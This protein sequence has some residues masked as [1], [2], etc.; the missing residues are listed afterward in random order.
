MR[1]ILASKSPRRKEILLNMGLA[2][3]IVTADTD[4]SSD[5]TD[6]RELCEELSLRKAIAVRDHLLAIGEL[7]P[8][9][10]II[11]SDTVVECEGEIL[12]KPKDKE[13]A[14]RMLTSLSGRAHRVFSG[15]ALV[16]ADESKVSHSVTAVY[17]DEIE[18]D[19]LERYLDT[20]E[21]YD[22][23]GAYGIQGY[24][25]RWIGRIDGC[26]FGVVG[27]SANVLDKLHRELTGRPIK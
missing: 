18:K 22:K 1:Y 24:A 3:D 19:D 15:I 13:D 14:R 10:I 21:P 17:V 2:F 26:Y 5:I 11:A 16:R 6:A 20:N 9:D 23:A 8:A 27:M 4:E 12:G 25:G 7:D